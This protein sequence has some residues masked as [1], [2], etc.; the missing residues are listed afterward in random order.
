MLGTA[1]LYDLCMYACVN[2]ISFNQG[3]NYFKKQ[4]G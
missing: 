3:A 4:M 1:L 2:Y